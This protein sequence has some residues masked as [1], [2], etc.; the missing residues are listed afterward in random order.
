M[1]WSRHMIS[2]KEI[3]GLVICDF[4]ALA[5]HN[6]TASWNKAAFLEG[7]TW[8]ES[9]VWLLEFF[10]VFQFSNLPWVPK[11]CA[12]LMVFHILYYMSLD[13]FLE[14]HLFLLFPKVH[15]G[16]FHSIHRFSC[17]CL[18]ISSIMPWPLWILKFTR[19]MRG[20][21][22]FFPSNDLKDLVI[23]TQWNIPIC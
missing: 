3:L 4:L 13:K 8:H 11:K 12:T 6:K 5:I 14:F 1:L 15:V 19:P 16:V 20:W 17:V 18:F 9:E 10:H 22:E 21:P 23:E 7:A 2:Q